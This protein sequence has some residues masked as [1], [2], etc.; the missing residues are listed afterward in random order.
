M[1]D[2]DAFERTRE[3]ECT[4]QGDAIKRDIASQ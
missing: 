2:D 1:I 3:R 4:G